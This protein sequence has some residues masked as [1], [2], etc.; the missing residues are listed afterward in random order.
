MEGGL[1]QKAISRYCK[2]E[3]AKSIYTDLE[4]SKYVFQMA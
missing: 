1:S 4:R 3:K 2:G